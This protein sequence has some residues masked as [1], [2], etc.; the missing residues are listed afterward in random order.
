MFN[1]MLLVKI[2]KFFVLLGFKWKIEEESVDDY[3]FFNM[4]I[5]LKF[6][7]VIFCV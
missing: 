1:L 4:Y 2:K 5:V 6:K 7:N 3:L